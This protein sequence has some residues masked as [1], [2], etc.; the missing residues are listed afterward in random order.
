MTNPARSARGT[1][2]RA[3]FDVL[4]QDVRYALRGL[5]RS[6][7]FAAV[8]ILSLALGV[9]A[10]TAI[11]SL[12]DAILIRPL[13][14]DR[15]GELV[16]FL[17]KYPNEPRMNGSWSWPSYEH[18]RGH[19]RAFSA[20]SGSSYDLRAVLR[21]P[22]AAAVSG[23][24]ERV[25]PDYFPFLGVKPALGRTIGA[26]DP[27]GA[28]AVLSWSLWQRD[29][30]GDPAALGQPI[31]VGDQPATVVGVAPRRFTGLVVGVPTD[32]WIA[33][34]S[35]G[36]GGGLALVARLKPG[37]T[38]AQA[39]SEM[40]ALY[41]FTIDERAAKSPDPVLRELRVEV[42]PAAGGLSPARD[43]YGKPLVTL[44]TISGL[45]LLLTC[46]NL[47]SML[48]ARGAARSREMAVRIG[49]GAGP[50]R[51]VRQALTE[52]LLLS[53]AGTVAGVVAAWFA[54]ASLVRII[55]G[56]R[57]LLPLHLPAHPD[58]R[59]LGFAAALALATGLLFGLVPAW[60]AF[61][62][63]PG[64]A[65]RQA[66]RA[67]DTPLRR[68]FGRALVASQVALSVL[69]LSA[70]AVFL[71]HL[72]DLRG[73]TLGFQSENVLIVSLDPARAGMRRSQLAQP[74]REILARVE[75]LPGVR[76][77][78]IAGATP[79]QGAGAS[80]FVTAEG[81]TE[82]PEDRRYVSLNWVAPRY[83]ETLGTPLLAG[84]DFR[85]EDAG[86]TRVA[87]VNRAFADHFFAGRDPLG[88]RVTVDG[89]TMP[90][91][92]VGVVGNAKYTELHDAPPRTLYMNMWQESRIFSQFVIRADRNPAALAGPFRRIAGE[93]ARNVPVDR[94]LTLSGQVDAAMVPERLVAM[95]S[96][97]FGA[98]AAA[99]AGIGLYGLLAHTV[100]RRVNEIGVRM[101]LGATAGAVTRMILADAAAMVATGVLAGIPL[102]MLGRSLA[103]SL[104]PDLAAPSP[105][106]LAAA[107]AAIGMVALAA[108][109]IP[110]RRAAR[111]EP[112]AALRAE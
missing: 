9:G 5:R 101:A 52:S 112:M 28:V 33:R 66:G 84:R 95:L 89:D 99:L 87:I 81:H 39:R 44:L 111:V 108:A 50:G 46:I 62:A 70:A 43:R 8:A 54:T 16:E 79:I 40:T 31:V 25:L 91:E 11:F 96:G 72:S 67:G 100:A 82:R 22:G 63:T 93:A 15:P 57:S 56:E 37:V 104:F 34:G 53:F 80:R 58:L 90:Y 98:L 51:L 76:S 10:N 85:F 88:R 17:Q 24:V 1:W 71:G 109:G 20:V 18:I 26:G 29:F 107:T 13:P 49:L 110:A 92:V 32:V 68:W 65:L 69:L 83:F 42:E 45:L 106:P 35:G 36:P 61:R 55:A 38:L 12:M 64:M 105:A 94:V 97:F 60:N 75:A 77:A 3:S 4:R 73:T 41:R 48:L 23:V 103:T 2:D 47:A 78:S 21:A 59:V 6:P 14:V 102:A 19:N 7:G 74:Y 30:H 86:R 27:A